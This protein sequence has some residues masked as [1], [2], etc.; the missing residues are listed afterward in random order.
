MYNYKIVAEDI[1]DSLKTVIEKSGITTEF[2]LKDVYDHKLKVE[3][4]LKEKQGMVDIAIAS[5]QNIMNNHK[6]VA[7]IINSIKKRENAQGLLATIYLYI[8]HDIDRETNQKMVAERQQLIEEYEK[9]LD[10]I[11][12]TLSIPKPVKISY[13]KGEE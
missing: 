6:D 1:V 13:V 10:E 3:Q 12:E 4:D 9:E 5:M 2:T 8:K 11:H 7:K